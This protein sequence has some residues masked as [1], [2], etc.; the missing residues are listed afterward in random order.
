[1]CTLSGPR[2]MIGIIL[3]LLYCLGQVEEVELEMYHN[4]IVELEMYHNI[5]VELEMH[6][7]IIVELEMHL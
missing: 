5:I 1:M 4:I 7:N 6:H 3:L 2:L